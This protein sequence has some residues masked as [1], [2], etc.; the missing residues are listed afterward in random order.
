MKS[1][2]RLALAALCL[3]LCASSAR[4]GEENLLQTEEGFVSQMNG[5][6]VFIAPGVYEVDLT[7]GEK[8][9]VG[10][11]EE[12]RR[13]DQAR[14]QAQLRATK[15]APDAAAQK[16][17][18]RVLTH[19]LRGLAD[20]AP[21][22]QKAAVTGWTCNYPFTLDGGYT[23]KLVGGDTWGN[24]SIGVDLDFGPP[25]PPSYFPKRTAYTYVATT[26]FPDQ[27]NPYYAENFQQIL[28]G[29]GTARTSAVVNCGSAVWDCATWESFSYVRDYGCTNGYRSIDRT[30]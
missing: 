18:I 22:E 6:A 29:L 27:T 5:R 25:A 8:I 9:R 13:Y 28:S 24:A 7:S 11:G 12:G 15:A 20:Q 10:F 2:S 1:S 16:D 3:T 17:K 21:G 4:A 23:P 26:A 30:N 14:L 19:A